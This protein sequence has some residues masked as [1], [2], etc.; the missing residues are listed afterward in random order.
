MTG[1]YPAPTRLELHRQKFPALANKTYF[2][3][4]GQGTLPQASLEA[5]QQAYEYVQRHGPFS[6]GVNAWVMEE[7]HQTRL[8]IASELVASVETI[9]LTEDVT[10][11][12]NIAMWGIDWQAGDHMLLTDCEHPGIF[13]TAQEIARRFKVEVSTCPIMDTLN[14]GDPTAV[15]AQHLRPR[16]RLVVLSHVLWNTGQVLPVAEIVEVCR[17]Y[18][19][20]TKSLRVLVDAAQSVGSLPLNLTELGQ[21]SML[22][23]VTSGYVDQ[24]APVVS[25]CD[26]TPWKASI[27]RSLVGV[28]L[29]PVKL[30]NQWA[31]SLMDAV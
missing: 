6:A 23:R 26:Q 4:G 24:K 7:A 25:T 16:T 1:I 18:S 12:C 5:I 27:Q 20:G 8:A 10:V 19:T 29:L 17:N 9:A 2:N 11:G 13:A 15:I 21:T 22:S 3:F 28:A 14:Q 30:V 31:G